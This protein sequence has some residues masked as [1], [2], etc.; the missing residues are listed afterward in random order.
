MG[1][2]LALAIPQVK[3][4]SFWWYNKKIIQITFKHKTIH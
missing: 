1:K 2:T 4:W 3:Y